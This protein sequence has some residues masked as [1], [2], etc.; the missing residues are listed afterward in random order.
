MQALYQWQLADLPWETIYSQFEGTES[1]RGADFGYFRG[2]FEQVVHA[3]DALNEILGEALDRPTGQLDPV[4]RAI[5]MIGACELAH[6]PEVPRGVVINEAVELAKRYGA[7][8]SHRY[9]NGVLD[10]CA[11]ILR[12]TSASAGRTGA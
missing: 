12:G 5:L 10:K 6:R 4:E 3:E 11:T 2:L 7:T 8:G 9:V 1:A